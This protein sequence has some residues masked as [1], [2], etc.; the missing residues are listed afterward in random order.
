[1]IGTPRRTS[2]LHLEAGDQVVERGDDHALDLVGVGREAQ[3]R[4]DQAD[5]GVDLVAGDEGADRGQG[6]GDLDVGAVEADLL[7]GLAQGGV[8]QL[9]AGVAAAAGE[10]DLA[11]VAAQVVAALGEDE[12]GA[13]GQPWSGTRTAASVRPWASI[14]RASCGSSRPR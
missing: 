7:L 14:S 3:A 11:G 4:L 9:L 6:A 2:A 8:E 1:M 13:S 5:E 10:R 12:A